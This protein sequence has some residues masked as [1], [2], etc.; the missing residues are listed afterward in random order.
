MTRELLS[1]CSPNAKSGRRHPSGPP[2]LNLTSN[3]NQRVLL[4]GTVVALAS[5]SVTENGLWAKRRQRPEL[6]CSRCWLRRFAIRNLS[7]LASRSP[8]RSAMLNL[9]SKRDRCISALQKLNLPRHLPA[10]S[11]ADSEARQHTRNVADQIDL[12]S[13]REL[14]MG[15]CERHPDTPW[16]GTKACSCGGAGMPCPGCNPT[17]ELTPS[18]LLTRFVDKDDA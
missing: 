18:R 4:Q 13:V 10:A 11:R 16:L 5:P 1:V 12:F 15:L 17:D 9:R 2:P 6:S 3:L 14:Q 7:R 8:S